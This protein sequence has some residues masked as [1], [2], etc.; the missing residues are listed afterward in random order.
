MKKEVKLEQYVPDYYDNIKD[1]RELM[2]TENPLFKD[3]RLALL[4]INLSCN[5]MY[6]L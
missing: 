4:I 3:G 5:V 6:K 2:K 1:M